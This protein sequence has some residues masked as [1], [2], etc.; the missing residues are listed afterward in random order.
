MKRSEQEVL[1]ATMVRWKP[2]MT[3]DL[4]EPM[5]PPRPSQGEDESRLAWARYWQAGALHSCA[6][7]F[8]G[9]YDGPIADF[10]RSVFA[11]L[12]PGDRVLDVA[13]GN[14]A[15]ARMLI[16]TRTEASITC[17]SVDLAPVTPAWLSALPPGQAA[18][19]RF[20]GSMHAE[21]LPFTEGTYAL[22]ISQFGLEYTDLDRSVPE[23]LRV[24]RRPATFAAVIHHIG[25]RP[26]Q[27]AAEELRHIAWA[28]QPD[29]LMARASRM[30]EPMAR[31]ATEAGRRSLATDAGALDAREQFNACQRELSDIASRSPC[32]DILYELRE[33]IATVISTATARGEQVA[34]TAL[35]G[36]GQA[37]AD[38]RARLTDMGRAAMDEPK[39]QSLLLRLGP[40]TAQRV[41]RLDHSGHLMGW[42]VQVTLA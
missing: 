17:D 41:V 39:L 29:G 12:S 32:P 10:W 24:L 26:L 23:L 42:A 33:A 36:V 31:A 1:H 30:L 14:G 37:V 25:S 4:M 8:S 2:T 27:M 16:D 3:S 35:Q 5:P 40:S 18:R 21:A 9:N 13:S 15:L 19:V 20:F 28:L 7:S 6:T 34:R 22:A 11:P 38:N